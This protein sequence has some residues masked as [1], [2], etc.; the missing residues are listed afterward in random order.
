MLE[1]IGDIELARDSRAPM[2]ITGETGTG[3]ELLALAAHVLSARRSREFVAFN[4]ASSNRELI[5]S[6]LFGHGRGS[7]TGAS[8]DVRGI[9]R[10]A[11]GGTLLLDEIGELSLDVQPKLLR[12][13]QEGEVHPVG[14]PKPIKTDVRVIAATNRDLEADVSAGRFRADLFERLNVVRLHIPP[15]RERREE[16]SLLIEHF[17]D[18]CQREEH[19]QGLRLSNEATELL[20]GYDWPHNARQLE[21]EVRQL[22]ALSWN[23]EVI[24]ADRLSLKIRPEDASPSAPAAALIEDKIVIDANLSNGEA[25]D[26]L[27]RQLIIHALRKTGGNRRQAAARLQMDRGGLKRAI[28]RL[29]IEVEGALIH[30]SRE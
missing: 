29:G 16:I 19:K 23:D 26:E 21:N 22:V 24:G 17:M 25:K 9:I 8:A 18:R 13:L 15:L 27:Q 2:L 5:E 3:K 28:G 12:F 10:E 14:A 20:S 7:F 30:K 4:C 6:Q 11:D 1:L